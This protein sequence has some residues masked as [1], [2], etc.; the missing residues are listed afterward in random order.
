MKDSASTEYIPRYSRAMP[1]QG[2]WPCL[3]RHAHGSPPPPN[4]LSASLNPSFLF[5]CCSTTSRAARPDLGLTLYKSN[6]KK[7]GKTKEGVPPGL[8]LL[9]AP[10]TPKG[11]KDHQHETGPFVLETARACQ[12]SLTP[13]LN[14]SLGPWSPTRLDDVGR[15]PSRKHVATQTTRETGVGR[16]GTKEH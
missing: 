6:P 12:T 8:S 5:C 13:P 10:Y 1:W 3:P 14:K 9:R 4:T 15:V 2:P 7:K 11:R 16:S